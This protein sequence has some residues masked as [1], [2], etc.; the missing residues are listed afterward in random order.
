MTPLKSIVMRSPAKI[1]IFLESHGKRP[2]GFHNLETVMLRTQLCDTIQY[3]LNTQNCATLR[4]AADA[5]TV[6]PGHF[7]LDNSNLI[8]RAASAL[9]QFCGVQAG[10]DIV[11]TKRIPAEAGLAGGSSNAATTL[12]ALNKLWQLQLSTKVLHEIAAT[13]GSDVNFLISG[14][15]AA[16]CRGRGEQVQPVP[17]TGRIHFVACRPFQGNST[18]KVFGAL[19][20][21]PAIQRVHS[22]LNAL[23]IGRPQQ[24][25]THTYNALASTACGENEQMAQLLKVMTTLYRRPAF[26]SGSGSTC[27][28]YARGHREASVISRSMHSVTG[29]P[30]WHLWC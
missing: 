8:L 13:L 10:V 19:R 20:E 17:V 26:M 11:A 5:A 18:A 2:D 7:P 4:L 12:L 1:N 24:L 9:R 15:R 3:S 16:V 28:V 23:R 27:F 22:V 6:P 29:F 14:Y 30:T 25:E 21:L